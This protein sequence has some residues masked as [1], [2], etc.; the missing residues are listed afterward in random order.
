L[1]NS[2]V[3]KLVVRSPEKAGVGGSRRHLEIGSLKYWPWRIQVFVDDDN[4]KTEVIG[5]DNTI[6]TKEVPP[7][8]VFA[9]PNWTILD[10]DLSKYSGRA[11]E[12][13]LYQ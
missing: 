10:V 8:A 5:A 4:T 6:N 13:R 2:Q 1:L 7:N 12:L 11:V 3:D 9:I